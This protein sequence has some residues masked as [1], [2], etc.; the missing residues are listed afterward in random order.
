MLIIK[1]LLSLLGRFLVCQNHL[2]TGRVILVVEA[3]LDRDCGAVVVILLEHC[4]S[5]SCQPK[6]GTSYLIGRHISL[7]QSETRFT[8]LDQWESLYL[9]VST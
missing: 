6:C 7:A 2:H 3:L 1:L 9:S 8:F 4:L 5:L